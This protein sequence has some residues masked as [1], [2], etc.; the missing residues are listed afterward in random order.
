MEWEQSGHA[1][2][3]DD[4]MNGMTNP[5]FARTTGGMLRLLSRISSQLGMPG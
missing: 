5:A 3:P 4:F 2:D 1:L